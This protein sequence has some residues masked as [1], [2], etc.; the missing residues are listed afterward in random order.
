M[1]DDVIDVS[2]MSDEEHREHMRRIS[3]LCS[4]PCMTCVRDCTTMS[5]INE[6]EPYQRW[7]DYWIPERRK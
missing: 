5:G 2:H 6:C 4:C 1:D 3:Q 7:M